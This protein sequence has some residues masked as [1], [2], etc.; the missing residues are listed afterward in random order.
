MYIYIYIYIYNS[1]GWF[2]NTIFRSKQHGKQHF[3]NTD[4]AC[5]NMFFETTPFETTPYASPK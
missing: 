4:T 2:Q 3:C 1:Y 5:N